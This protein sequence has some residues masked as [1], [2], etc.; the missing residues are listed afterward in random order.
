[1]QLG[2]VGLGKMGSGMARRWLQAGSQV[3][4]YDRQPDAGTTLV[5][6]GMQNAADLADLVAQLT[7]PRAIWVMLPAGEATEATITQLGALLAPGDCLIDSGNSH[8]R[9]T[10]RRATAL[11]ERG[12]RL[13]DQGTSGGVWGLASGYCLM[14][15]GD[16][17]TIA[18][19]EPAF[20]QLAPGDQYAHVGAV[21]AGHF[22]K[23]VHNG[24]EYGMM[25][26]YAEGF[27]LL[28]ANPDFRFDL[29]QVAHLWNNGSVVRSWLLE[30]AERALTSDADL[31]LSTS[32][33][34]DSGEGR[35]MAQAAIE[36]AVPLPV[37]TLALMQRFSS[38]QEAPF[39]ARLLNALRREFGGH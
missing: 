11:A 30:L 26:S 31:Q 33:V 1:M 17:A 6:E 15:G 37:I 16:P 29:A 32:A 23:M 35:W 13:V 18:W 20:R 34:A 7:P 36:A 2:I 19:L 27:E 28:R 38:R 21:G 9:D 14:V 10:V 39:S 3:V 12:I 22:A 8:Y 5:A 4:G 24:I 25:Q